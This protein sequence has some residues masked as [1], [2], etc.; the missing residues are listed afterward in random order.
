MLGWWLYA[1]AV[2][3]LLAAAAWT[4]ERA[5]WA[6]RRASRAIWALALV[7]AVALPLAAELLGTGRSAPA[8]IVAEALGGRL[9][10]VA[11]V[12]SGLSRAALPWL[13]WAW[14]I[15][16]L[17]LVAAAALGELCWRRGGYR[18]PAR[19]CGVEVSLSPTE[20]PALLGLWRPRVLLPAWILSVS[21]EERRLAVAHELNH[22][23]SGDLLLL[24][25]AYLIVCMIPWNPAAWWMFHRLQRAVE[26][27]CDR[28]VLATRCDRHAYGRLLVRAAAMRSLHPFVSVG[29]L[30]RRSL[31]R[32]RMLRVVLEQRGRGRASRLPIL[33][34][35]ACL[36]A[37]AAV[38]PPAGETFGVVVVRP[39]STYRLRELPGEQPT[40]A[41]RPADP[42][43]AVAPPGGGTARFVPKSTI[44]PMTKR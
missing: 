2:G 18:I 8:R 11:D 41:E 40:I 39:M 43:S 22:A 34:A 10:P 12:A 15:T 42:D 20:G 7:A 14:A 26:I 1:S 31:V 5:V 33:G 13:P 44:R 23:R 27:D 36:T 38:P 17:A 30:R 35:L 37:I 29:L 21:R 9:A 6:R 25:G 32:D 28:R 19:V 16:S 3:A 4:G 24:W